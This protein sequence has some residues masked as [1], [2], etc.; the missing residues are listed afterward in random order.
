MFSDRNYCMYA[1]LSVQKIGNSIYVIPI[2]KKVDYVSCE[3]NIIDRK[4]N[5]INA[6]EIIYGQCKLYFDIDNF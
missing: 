4:D 6:Y 5:N 2:I 3:T 1:N